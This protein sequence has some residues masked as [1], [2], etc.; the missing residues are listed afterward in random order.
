MTRIIVLSDTHGH[1]NEFNKIVNNTK[2]EATCYIH[3][4]D[5][6]KE[7]EDI[8]FVHPDITL[9]AVRGN[10][11]ND[12]TLPIYTDIKIGNKI[13]FM[14]HGDIFN[15]KYNL[16]KLKSVARNVN[17]DIALYG[18]SHIGYQETDEGLLILNPGSLSYPRDFKRS[19][20]VID[21]INDNIITNFVYV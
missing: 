12:M 7:V 4:G 1:F 9:Y 19:Y 15:V 10:C 5:G 6:C 8:R 14:T 17:A 21:I 16:N 2:D 13:I 18:H 20:A 11:D 3:L